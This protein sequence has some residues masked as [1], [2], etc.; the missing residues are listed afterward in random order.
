MYA[1]D[2]GRKTTKCGAMQSVTS[3]ADR[4]LQIRRPFCCK[5]TCMKTNDVIA[6]RQ[7]LENQSL[8]SVKEV[9]RAN[10]TDRQFHVVDLTD[11]LNWKWQTMQ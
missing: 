11:T 2:L 8:F 4:G 1:G 7:K 3:S 6:I 10:M 9:L 5:P